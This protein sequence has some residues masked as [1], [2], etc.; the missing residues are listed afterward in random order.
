MKAF[1]RFVF[2]LLRGNAMQST[3]QSKKCAPGYVSF[4]A[5]EQVGIPPNSLKDLVSNFLLNQ[6]L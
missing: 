2:G 6:L 5:Y 1:I 3:L 4:H